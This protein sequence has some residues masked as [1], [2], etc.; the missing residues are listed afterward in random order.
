M[1]SERFLAS[2]IESC[3]DC[4][5]G[6]KPDGTILTWNKGAERIF[7]LSA[8]EM[9]GSNIKLLESHFQDEDF[10]SMLN[11]ALKG[12]DIDHYETTLKN[13]GKEIVVSV[14]VS[15]VKS[16]GEIVGISYIA[17]DISDSKAARIMEQQIQLHEQREDFVAALTHDL[18]NPIIG[19]HRILG[20]IVED[21]VDSAKQPELFQKMLASHTEVL[22]IINDLLS[23]F[24]FERQTSYSERELVDYAALVGSAVEMLEPAAMAKNVQFNLSIKPNLYTIGEQGPLRRVVTNLLDNALKFSPEFTTIK[25]ELNEHSNKLILNITDQGAGIPEEEQLNLFHKFWQG[26]AGK[27]YS[28]GSGLGLY[29][30][31]QIIEAHD[32]RILCSS[33]VNKGTT[34]TVELNKELPQVQLKIEKSAG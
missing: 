9:L 14:S 18:K 22:Q 28:L 30:C 6:I 3:Q 1:D 15:P 5:L 20:L 8:S 13:E 25:V 27:T 32:G 23:V 10:E 34:F 26:R 21:K 2:I 4:I 16:R 29:L 19:C 7:G 31:R 24:R 12:A 11:I 17:R 33:R